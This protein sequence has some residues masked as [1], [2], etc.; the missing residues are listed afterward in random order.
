[1]RKIGRKKTRACDHTNLA[2]ELKK[3]LFEWIRHRTANINEYSARYSILEDEFYIPKTANLAK[4]SSTNKQGRSQE[5]DSNLAKK[6]I[7]ILKEDA[8]R[9][10]NNYLWMLN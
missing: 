4:Q 2:K 5:L 8:E 10:Y 3:N 9:N 6:I 1:M 7:K